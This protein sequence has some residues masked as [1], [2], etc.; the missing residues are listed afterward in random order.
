MAVQLL[1]NGVTLS[2]DDVGNG[3]PVVFLHGVMMSRQ[4][5][6]HQIPYFSRYY[7]A[8]ALDFRGHGDSDK[9]LSGHTVST[10]AHDLRA[11]F[12]VRCVE[13][14]VLV[15][16]SMGAMVIFEYL[17]LFGQ[18]DV[19]GIVIIDQPPSDFV[20]QG[21]EFGVFTL[22]WLIRSVEGLQTDQRALVRNFVDLML[23][24]PVKPVVDWMVEEIVKVPP[25]IAVS[26]LMTQTFRDYRDFF[27]S[28]H[29]PTMVVFGRDDKLTSPRAG[30][31]IASQVP[32]AKLQIFE[33]SS[34]CPF[35]EEPE[36]FNRVLHEFVS[37]L[38]S[39]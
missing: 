13:H 31:Y 9:V 22:E 28:I 7:R 15:G 27:S 5:F 29:V 18:G 16:W 23:H 10:Y 35:Y 8:L 34:H 30:E 17:K 21:Y 19:A 26:I 3:R 11:L 33:Q 6:K 39:D 36:L 1:G 20:W 25:A 32:A 12:E 38:V 14:P 2:F 4:F 37:S 24:E